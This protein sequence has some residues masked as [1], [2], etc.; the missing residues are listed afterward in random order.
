MSHYLILQAT[1]ALKANAGGAFKV[2][3]KRA[4]DLLSPKIPTK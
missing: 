2:E 3:I 4:M 1:I